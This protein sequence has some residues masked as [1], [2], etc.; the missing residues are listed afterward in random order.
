MCDMN[1]FPGLSTRVRC[2]RTLALCL[3][4]S[5]Y[6][7]TGVQADAV[8]VYRCVGASGEIGFQQ[9]PCRVGKEQVLHIE[10]VKVG[11]DA[12]VI[13]IEPRRKPKPVKRPA[14]KKR[15][16]SD[17]ACFNKRQR[18]ESVN[19]KLRRGY[20][21]GQGADLRHRRRQYEAYL[22]RYCR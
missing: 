14:G 11:W 20:K 13:Q 10:D 2:H 3:S 22:S 5:L 1:R 12:P 21:A 4:L 6:A 7:A 18:L 15:K 9:V 19:R 16:T 8:R 17:K